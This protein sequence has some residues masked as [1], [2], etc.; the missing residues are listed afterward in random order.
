MEQGNL[1]SDPS[2]FALELLHMNGSY[3]LTDRAIDQEILR[4]SPGNYALGYMEDDTFVVFYVGRSDSDLRAKLHAWVGAPSD[5]RHAPSGRAPWALR[6]SGILPLGAPCFAPV[7]HC[8][9][10]GY[11]RFAFSYAPSSQ[12]AFEKECRNY[13]DFGR[14]N[15]LDNRMAPVPP[16]TISLAP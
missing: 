6:A 4:V 1:P 16:P 2:S 8:S 10:P 7:S 3:P 5:D 12:A 14:Y 13:D 15:G 11:T 9:D